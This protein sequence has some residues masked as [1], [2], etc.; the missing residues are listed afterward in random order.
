MRV[1]KQNDIHIT[2]SAM[3]ITK[4]EETMK[5]IGRKKREQEEQCIYEEER[6]KME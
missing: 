5:R 6:N 4:T 2:E 3:E 1:S